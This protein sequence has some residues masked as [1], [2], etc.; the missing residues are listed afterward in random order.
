MSDSTQFTSILVPTDGSEYSIAAGKLAI[1]MAAFHNARLTFIYVIDEAIIEEL[2]RSSQKTRQEI[3]RELAENGQRYLDYLARLAQRH[4]IPAE[5]ILREGTPHIEIVEEARKK[6]ADLI[7]MG[8]VGRRGPRRI[9]IGSV[10]ERV[11]EYAECPVLITKKE[12]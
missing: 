12:R 9:L 2:A 1:D 3:R 4:G 11:I 8:Q 6:M 10:A 5:K 7:V